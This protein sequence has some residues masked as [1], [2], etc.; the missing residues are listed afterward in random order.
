MFFP[1][2]SRS[3]SVMVQIQ[4][5]HNATPSYNVNESFLDEMHFL[6][7]LYDI[8]CDS[9]HVTVTQTIFGNHTHYTSV[10][11]ESQWLRKHYPESAPL[12]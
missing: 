5:L 8:K 1:T 9:G 11:L 12:T 7:K 6:R 3:A 2:D 4:W 10:S